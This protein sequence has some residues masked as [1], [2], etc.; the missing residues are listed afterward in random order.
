MFVVTAPAGPTDLLVM[1]AAQP[2]DHG[3][4]QPKVD[5]AFRVFPTGAQAAALAA[6]VPGPLP[7]LAGRAVCAAGGACDESYGAALV[8]VEVVN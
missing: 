6:K 2:R 1:V 7:A 4:L 3:L 5:G 8:R